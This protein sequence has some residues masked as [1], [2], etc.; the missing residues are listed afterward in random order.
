[1]KLRKNNNKILFDNKV[2]FNLSLAPGTPIQ[3][4]RL[5]SNTLVIL[6]GSSDRMNQWPSGKD[7]L[8]QGRESK[9]VITLHAFLLQSGQQRVILG[10]SLL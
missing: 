6:A 8:Q 4:S 2:I 3:S 10:K 1:M 7:C 9:E 5:P